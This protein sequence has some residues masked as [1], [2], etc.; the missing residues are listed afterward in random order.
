[1]LAIKETNVEIIVGDQ[2]GRM[3]NSIQ[4]LSKTFHEFLTFWGINICEINLLDLLSPV[5]LTL[6]I[7]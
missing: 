3:D 1:M 2:Y 4:T 7:Y 6:L 5:I